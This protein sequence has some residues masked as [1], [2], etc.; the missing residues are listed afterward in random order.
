MQ[1]N[2]LGDIKGGQSSQ[3]L[4]LGTPFSS[5][6]ARR[7]PQVQLFWKM[8]YSGRLLCR[9]ILQGDCWALMGQVYAPPAS[10]KA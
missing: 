10:S 7:G 9:A 8:R 1:H 6:C 3:L 5:L 4:G 2:L